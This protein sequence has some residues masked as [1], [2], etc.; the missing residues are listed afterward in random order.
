MSAQRA[1]ITRHRTSVDF[2]STFG[3]SNQA[4]GRVETSSLGQRTVRN[5]GSGRLS[6]EKATDYSGPMYADGVSNKST[7]KG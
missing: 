3:D 4:P 5:L 1:G 2:R 6:S 7:I